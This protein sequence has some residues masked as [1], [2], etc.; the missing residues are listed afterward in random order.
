MVE[1][2]AFKMYFKTLE[3]SIEAKIDLNELDEA[4][5]LYE[6]AKSFL[7]KMGITQKKC[8]QEYATIY[9][10]LSIV[11]MNKFYDSDDLAQR[12]HYYDL[13]LK[14][15]RKGER[16]FRQIEDTYNLAVLLIHK[17]DL[18]LMVDG[19]VTK[20]IKKSNRLI[21]I[22]KDDRSR[23]GQEIYARLLTSI[24]SRYCS[25]SCLND[26]GISHKTAKR[27]L[28]EINEINSRLHPQNTNLKREIVK[29][30]CMLDLTLATSIVEYR[31]L[32]KRLER[33]MLEYK[34]QVE[35]DYN[36]GLYERYTADIQNCLGMLYYR[37]GVY[38]KSIKNHKKAIDFY[39]KAEDCYYDTMNFIA[40]TGG[41]GA[42]EILN[43]YKNIA[44]VRL[45]KYDCDNNAESIETI[46]NELTAVAERFEKIIPRDILIAEIYESLGRFNYILNEYDKS[47]S[48]FERAEQIIESYEDDNEK[49]ESIYW[50]CKDYSLT[51]V[52]VGEYEL[53]V[54]YL[55]IARD[56]LIDFGYEEESEEVLEIDRR[57]EK[58]KRP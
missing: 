5:E 44:S 58:S 3:K 29:L 50:L 54:E 11:Y 37:I 49:A 52:A 41:P 7:T 24:V 13:A 30:D 40:K 2:E 8:K 21:K 4:I 18:E 53:A 55:N 14:L 45:N 20:W 33:L 31:S 9:A 56:L 17:A 57:I 26:C 27:Y 51:L 39:S 28:I 22:I 23:R 15:M 48:Y 43:I 16:I 46:T 10:N 47:L 42:L 19:N 1:N 38:Y 36:E 32:I 35:M 12:G 6:K 25:S 34:Q